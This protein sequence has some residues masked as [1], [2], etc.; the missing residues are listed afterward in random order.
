M[1]VI[2]KTENDRQP[3]RIMEIGDGGMVGIRETDRPS[4]LY[5]WRWVNR[6]NL[7]RADVT[8]LERELKILEWDHYEESGE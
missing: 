4:M 6:K 8:D 2:C 5:A 1:Y 3:Y 7:K